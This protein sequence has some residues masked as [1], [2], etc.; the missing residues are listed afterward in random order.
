[1]ATTNDRSLYPPNCC[2][3]WISPE[4]YSPLLDPFTVK[5]YETKSR[6]RNAGDLIYCAFG[7]CGEILP[8]SKDNVKFVACSK[9]LRRTCLKFHKRGHAKD[10]DSERECDEN[11]DRALL[12]TLSLM[13]WKH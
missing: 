1:V 8:S 2:G 11:D 7:R 3:I 12:A 9:C 6:E 5:L 10:R 13:N 4:R